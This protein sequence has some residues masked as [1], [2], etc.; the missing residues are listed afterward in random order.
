MGLASLI[1]L[2]IIGMLFKDAIALPCLSVESKTKF[3]ATRKALTNLQSSI[4]NR[5][6]HLQNDMKNRIKN[7]DKDMGSLVS[8]F[9]SE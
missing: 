2:C 4:D 9:E 1:T 7:I 5:I 6:T 3:E 8:D